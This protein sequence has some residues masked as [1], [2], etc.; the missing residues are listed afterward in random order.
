MFRSLREFRKNKGLTQAELADRIGAVRATYQTYESGRSEIP[1]DIQVKL[2]KQGYDGPF[3]DSAR[4]ADFVTRE[5]FAEMKGDL[6]GQI[7]TLR[8]R[9]EDF[10]EVIRLIAPPK[11]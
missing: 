10:G 9:L 2:K 3:A 11:P 6:Q 8:E 5:E 4:A 1:R 7:R